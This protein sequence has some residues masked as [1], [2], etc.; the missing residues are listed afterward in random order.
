MDEEIKK[1]LEKN[2]KITEEIYAMTKKIK[3]HLAFQRLISVF[4]LIMFVVPIIVAVIYLPPLINNL[5]DQYKGVLDINLNDTANPLNNLLK[6]NY[7]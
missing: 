4:Y 1:L 7:K 2:L 6:D 5:V 3:S